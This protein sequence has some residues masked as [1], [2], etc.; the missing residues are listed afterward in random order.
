LSIADQCDGLRC[1]MAM[2]VTKDVFEKTWGRPTDHFWSRAIKN[3]RE[4]FP[5]F[6]FM[7]EVYWDMEWALQQEGFDFT[8]DKRLYDRLHEQN[9]RS[10]REHFYAEP[11][12]QVKLTRFLENHDEPR[13]ATAFENKV[14]K[15][16][17]VISFLCPGMRFFYQGQFEGRK[18]R[19]SPHLIRAPQELPDAELQL[20]YSELLKI[21]KKPIFKNGQWRLLEC[22][23]AWNG[24]ESWDSF[25]AF[26]WEASN[27]EK[28]FVIVNYASTNSQCYVRMPFPELAEQQ[29]RFSDLMGNI[30]YDRNGNEI[31]SGGIYLDLPAWGFH[32]FDVSVPIEDIQE[33]K[34][35]VTPILDMI[36]A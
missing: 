14:H 9:A 32:I 30:F 18:K 22:N 23:P 21:L 25:I 19:I 10:V 34:I 31:L 16:A 4:K 33:E 12:Y 36:S 17:A 1:D 35:K 20:F 2:L 28:V 26:A 11:G 7:A 5:D 13:A 24:N 27:G 29:V 6:C 15:A 3:V 8:Y